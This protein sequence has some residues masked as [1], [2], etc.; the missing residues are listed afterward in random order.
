MVVDA[1]LIGRLKPEG[2]DALVLLER[3]GH[4]A[5]EVFDERRLVVGEHRHVPLVLA[6]E[7][8]VDRRRRCRVADG[9]QLLGPDAL[10]AGVPASVEY[11][12]VDVPTLRMRAVVGDLLRAWAEAGDRDAGR[13]AQLVRGS[14]YTGGEGAVES[15]Q[16]VVS[17]DR[18]RPLDEQR[19]S[20]ADG[21]CPGG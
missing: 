18:G 4:V 19:E 14:P 13:Q 6:L 12:D 15:Q 11:L 1:L 8:R 2:G 9:Q 21:G 16:R 17:A 5:R 20:Q 10:R 3:N 7:Q